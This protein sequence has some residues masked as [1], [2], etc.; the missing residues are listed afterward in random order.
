ML[1]IWGQLSPSKLL[2]YNDRLRLFG[3][4]LN[5]PKKRTYLKQLAKGVG[6]K[7]FLNDDAHNPTNIFQNLTWDFSN[8]SIIIQLPT[9]ASDVKGLE[10]LDA[11]DAN[12]NTNTLQL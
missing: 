4:L 1:N 9:N 10:T 5:I 2:Y 3:I 11:N 6:N 7:D 8:E 12:T